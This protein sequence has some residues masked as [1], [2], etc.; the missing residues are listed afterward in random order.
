MADFYVIFI[1]TK[2]GT[3]AAEVRAKMDLALDWFR[4]TPNLWIVH[5]SS[6][7]DKWQIRLKPLVQPDGAL[8]ISR[9]NIE[10]SNGWMIDDFWVW[11]NKKKTRS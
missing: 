8:F 10:E 11:I 5:T 9:L 7:V 3:E 6:D 4:I 2:K 1:E